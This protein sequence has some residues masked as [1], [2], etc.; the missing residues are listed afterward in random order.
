VNRTPAFAVD[1]HSTAN[2]FQMHPTG[3]TS[4]GN[5]WDVPYLQSAGAKAPERITSTSQLMVNL[6]CVM[7]APARRPML[8]SRRGEVSIQLRAGRGGREVRTACR[9]GGSGGRASKTATQRQLA[10]NHSL[11]G[12]HVRG[13]PAAVIVSVK[14]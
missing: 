14:P 8:S 3:M 11:E 12:A 10:A 13:S 5:L 6:M 2:A 1:I 7:D 4:Q 9:D